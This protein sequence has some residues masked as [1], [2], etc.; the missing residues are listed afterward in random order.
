MGHSQPSA[1]LGTACTSNSMHNISRTVTIR[2]GHPVV[3]AG[4]EEYSLKGSLSPNFFFT[5]FQV[6]AGGR[7][8]SFQGSPILVSR[9]LG[10]Q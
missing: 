4:K 5:L 1:K 8:N 9:G 3:Q 2:F 10:S 6:L 7:G